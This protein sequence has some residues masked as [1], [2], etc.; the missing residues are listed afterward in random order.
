MADY[1]WAW[2]KYPTA[3]DSWT[4]GNRKGQRCQ[5]LAVGRRNA[6]LV[7]FEDGTKYITSRYGLRRASA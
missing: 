3:P 5:L 2:A 1:R 6:V 7:Q 4:P